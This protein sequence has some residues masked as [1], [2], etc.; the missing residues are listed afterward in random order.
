MANAA[1]R[2]C[3]GER[4]WVWCHAIPTDREGPGGGDGHDQR[5]WADDAEPQLRRRRAGAGRGAAATHRVFAMRI[6]EPSGFHGERARQALI[7]FCMEY[8][9]DC[10]LVRIRLIPAPQRADD[11]PPDPHT[12]L[13]HE[14]ELAALIH[15]AH[16]QGIAVEA[17]L[18]APTIDTSRPASAEAHPTEPPA[19]TAAPGAGHALDVVMAFNLEQPPAARF[20]GVQYDLNTDRYDLRPWGHR[21]RRTVMHG[22]LE[23]LEQAKAS[24]TQAKAPL[25]LSVS[26]PSWYDDPVDGD[27]VGEVDYYGLR[28]NFHQHIQDLTDYVAVVCERRPGE[29]ADG[30]LS[31]FIGSELDYAQWIGRGVCIGVRTTPNPGATD[32]TYYGRPTWEFWQHKREAYQSLAHRPEFAGYMVD[33]YTSFKQLLLAAAPAQASTQPASKHQVFG[34]WVWKD[35]W[36]TSEEEQDRLIAFCEQYGINL[37]PVQIHLDPSSVRRGQP[38]LKYPDQLRRLIEV[39]G[40]KGIRIEAL[41]GAPEMALA[42]N[43]QAVLAILDAIIKFN[44]SLGPYVSLAG[45]HYD[46]EPYLLPQWKTPQRHRVMRQ[47]LELFEAARL[48]LKLDA[49]HLTLSASIPFWYDKKITPEDSCIL[50]YNGQLKN[51]HEHIQDLTDYVAIMS[52]RRKALGED[53][54]TENVETERAYAE[55]IGRYICAGMETMYIPDRP[56]VSFHGLP[57]SEF[58]FQRQKIQQA[59]AHQGGYGG[60][61]VHSYEFFA[62]YL[63]Q[64]TGKGN[65][66]S[67]DKATTPKP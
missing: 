18:N 16:E 53:S 49:P 65:A 17:L 37:L 57:A 4:R 67:N 2:G 51:L 22:F 66:K 55:W 23:F 64:A 12:V 9:V 15:A 36:I 32:S 35:K 34:M 39:A 63:A 29:A 3:G 42:T 19:A 20:A 11:H 56:E 25:R 48:K 50:K 8:G 27:P 41:D 7:A 43:H 10:L 40:R 44:K 59:L 31:V 24:I 45:I 1:R 14:A 6:E 21:Q 62:P 13:Q 58:W 28:K 54:V 47:M 38:T 60:V 26:I 46:I 52:Y 5:R 33:R 61:V 30:D